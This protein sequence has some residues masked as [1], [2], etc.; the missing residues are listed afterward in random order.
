MARETKYNN[1]TSPELISKINKNNKD[2]QKEFLEYLQSIDRA[3]T[4]IYQ[5]ECDL[6]IFFVWNMQNN[7]NKDFVK[8]TKRDLTKFQNYMLNVWEWS[9]K[10][11]RRVKSTIS[12]MS[13]FIEN[14]LDEEP[15]YQDFKSIVK[16]IENPVNEVVREK[17]VFEPE[18]L[19]RLLDILVENHKYEKACALSLAMQ[20]GRRKSELPRFKVSYFNEENVVYNSLYVTPEKVTTKGRGSKGKLLTLY[21]FK[22]DFDPYLN[23]WLNERKKLGINS[24]W[25]FPKKKEGVWLDEQAT[26]DT[27]NSWA[28]SFTQILGKDF[29]WHSVRHYWTT[30]TLKKLPANVVKELSGWSDLN[31]VDLYND[32]TISDTLSMYFDENGMKEIKQ[33]SLQD[34]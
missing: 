24:E 23:L 2:L 9:P 26:I 7:D 27:F 32:Q 28:N 19:Q 20:S 16:K 21:V 25:L 6:N 34:L 8:I 22:K 13:N 31:L 30:Q 11:I 1:I 15:E 29:Y 4:T 3:K 17:S 5:Y 18:E 12:S 33:Q 10:R 14:I